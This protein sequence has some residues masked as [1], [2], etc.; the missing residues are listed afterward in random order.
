MADWKGT[1]EIAVVTAC[2]NANGTPEL[3][4]NEVE[5]TADEAANGVHYYLVEAELMEAG[6]EEPYVHFDEMES[7]AFLHP[8]VRHD[9]GLPPRVTEPNS[10]APSEDP[11]CASSK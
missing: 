1:R 3:V 2:M 8:A 6:Y 11:K 9:L 5:V 7:P 4:L 10:L